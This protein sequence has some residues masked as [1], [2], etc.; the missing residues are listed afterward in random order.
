MATL[1]YRYMRLVTLGL[2]VFACT[3]IGHAQRTNKPEEII[4]DD[5]GRVRD[6]TR[7]LTKGDTVL[8][9]KK[10]TYR[11][12]RVRKAVKPIPAK[13][14]TARQTRERYDLPLDTKS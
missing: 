13:P 3:V 10:P 12:K 14:K 9:F 8:V 1:S 6:T 11:L 4:S 5:L 2:L 7:D